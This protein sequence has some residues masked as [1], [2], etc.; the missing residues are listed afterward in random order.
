MKK[1]RNYNRSKHPFMLRL[2]ALYRVLFKKEFILI[3]FK[4][5][6]YENG[7]SKFFIEHMYRSNRDINYDILILH[8]A[9]CLKLKEKIEKENSLDPSTC[10]H[11]FEP[12]SHQALYDF[13]ICKNCG[14][15]N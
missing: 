14:E 9:Y 3:N 7:E 4:G 10:D 12:A 2:I 11:K 1:S 6:D 5:G 15:L 13:D 8:M